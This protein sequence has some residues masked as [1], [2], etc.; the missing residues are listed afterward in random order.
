M[1]GAETEFGRYGGTLGAITTYEAVSHNVLDGDEAAGMWRFRPA[2]SETD[3]LILLHTEGVVWLPEH[4]RRTQADPACE[5]DECD[6]ECLDP[7]GDDAAQ[8]PLGD[9]GEMPGD[10][11]PRD[12]TPPPQDLELWDDGAYERAVQMLAARGWTL[13][14]ALDGSRLGWFHGQWGP[15]HPYVLTSERDQEADNGTRPW[16]QTGGRRL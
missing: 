3:Y 15:L 2:G 14:Q 5:V 1:I 16:V 7:A 10:W 9:L 13:D 11:D 4:W 12:R 8:T 6:I